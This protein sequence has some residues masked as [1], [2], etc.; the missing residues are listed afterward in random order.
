MRKFI[1]I[2]QSITDSGGHHL[3]Y[4]LRTLKAAK[5]NGF[6]TVLVT[7]QSFKNMEVNGIDIV[8]NIFK[9]TFWENLKSEQTFTSKAI[10]ALA[11][12]A[13]IIKKKLV[14]EFVKIGFEYFIEKISQLKHI[15][16]DR[17]YDTRN[18]LKKAILIVKPVIRILLNKLVRHVFFKK[19][20]DSHNNQFYKDLLLLHKNINIADNDI[21]FIPTIGNIE[22][23]G[24]YKAI[25]NHLKNEI[26]WHF[27]FRRNIFSGREFDYSNQIKY[28]LNLIETLSLCKQISLRKPLCLN[29]YTD[30]DLLSEQ[31]NLLGLV[32]FCTLPIPQDTLLNKHKKTSESTLNISYIGDARDEKGFHLL[33]D[34]VGKTIEAGYSSD[35][36]K[37]TIQSNFNIKGGES[38]TRKA[39]YQLIENYS[40]MV[41]IIDGP[42]NSEKYIDLINDSDII[43]I[44]YNHEHYYARSSGVFAEALAAGVPFIIPSKTWMAYEADRYNQFFYELLLLSNKIHQTIILKRIHSYFN[45]TIKCKSNTEKTNLIIKIEQYREN[46]GTYMDATWRNSYNST[47]N[48]SKYISSISLD[49]RNKTA[50]GLICIP[51]SNS[52]TLSFFLDGKLKSF[53]MIK[54]IYI[55][56]I[57]LSSNSTI[58]QGGVLYSND[59]D[60][61]SAIFEL[62]KKRSYYEKKMVDIRNEWLKKSSLNTLTTPRISSQ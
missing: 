60:I 19:N 6:K 12:R 46:P 10:K 55:Y 50:L 7:N 35:E 49:L 29:F 16:I 18:K 56:E 24:C 43:L 53:H 2:D 41:K 52:S 9:Y 14:S 25:K 21:V 44:P 26:N 34:I 62:I 38:K 13:G 57:E 42:F 11:R 33:P 3:E 39:R 27:L 1:L 48:K 4:A 17:K 32:K 30:T 15:D 37:F 28:Q 54:S 45:I 23:K 59:K 40:D 36:I 51:S 31:Y 61:P 20:M 22:L 5:K 8:E 47:V 58:Y